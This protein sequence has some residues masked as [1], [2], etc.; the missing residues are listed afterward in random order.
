MK[1]F[2]LREGEVYPVTLVVDANGEGAEVV[3][4]VGLLL[5]VKAV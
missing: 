2:D 3:V 4:F 1:G 5:W